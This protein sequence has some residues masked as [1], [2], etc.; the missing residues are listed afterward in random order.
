MSAT[1]SIKK[2]STLSMLSPKAYFA[3]KTALAVTVS[4]M[5]AM[6]M[7]WSQPYQGP[8]AIMVIASA[9]TLKESLGKGVARV[10]GTVAGALLGLLFIALF[11]QDTTLYFIALSI[12]GAIIVYL[13][14]SWQGDKSIWMIMLMVMVLIYNNGSVDDRVIYAIDRSWSTIF[15][16]FVYAVINIY[17]MPNKSQYSRIDSAIS[18]SKEWQK[19]VENLQNNFSFEPNSIKEKEHTLENAIRFG[20]TQYPAGIAFD[21]ARWELLLNSIYSINRIME[22]LSLLKYDIYKDKLFRVSAGIQKSID[23]ISN[24]IQEFESY[25]KKPHKIEL[26]NKTEI[27]I[28]K[29]AL[30]SF[31]TLQKAH[32]IT[33]VEELK[34]LQNVFIELLEQ[35]NRIHSSQPSIDDTLQIN[36]KHKL[37]RF[38]WGD[39]DDIKAT[40]TTILIFWSGLALWYFINTPQG[41]MVAAMA[42]SMSLLIIYTPLNP[43]ALIIIYSFSFLVSFLTYVWVLPQLHEWWQLGIY[44]FLYIF[45]A[46]YFIPVMLSLFFGLG[47]IFQFIDNTMFFS[48]QLFITI[49][50][51]FYLFLG[52]LLIFNYLPFPN[53]AEKIF[54]D[55]EN[56]FRKL[57]IYT[58]NRSI[59]SSFNS[60]LHKLRITL[61]YTTVEKMHIWASKLDKRYFSKVDYEMLNS[62]LKETK[63]LSTITELLES[64]RYSIQKNPQLSQI[65]KRVAETETDISNYLAKDIQNRRD[66]IIQ[67][68]EK[69]DKMISNL[70]LQDYTAKDISNISEYITLKKLFE[71]TLLKSEKMRAKAG[72]EQLKWSH[73]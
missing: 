28:N 1:E 14:Y 51:I 25:M 8:I 35:L 26:P 63:K 34:H 9:T 12:A 22:K 39:P 44:I 6:W 3:I 55:L 15:G 73:F 59:N 52:I 21:T 33:L 41:Y 30:K 60:P 61:L 10:L 72:L 20:D 2:K 49:L 53:R 27:I 67:R 40:F 19:F 69:L 54:L 4:Y 23:N 64:L 58:A 71:E 31:D 62:Y 29:E 43:M 42:F 17:I 11:P 18:L 37:K 5:V 50:L 45:F 65:K 70:N 47:L 46:Y 32:L 16:I 57:I 13:Y 24:M 66:F 56:R 36:I 68:V 38:V 48:F 7:S